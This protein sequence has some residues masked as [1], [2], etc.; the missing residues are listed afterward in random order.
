MFIEAAPSAGDVQD[1]LAPRAPKYGTAQ[2]DGRAKGCGLPIVSLG[3]H[4]FLVETQQVEGKE[5]GEERRFAGEEALHA[6][7]VS[8][9]LRFEPELRS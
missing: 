4:S 9:Q 5:H 6:E 1:G 2:K 7:A 3:R 8:V